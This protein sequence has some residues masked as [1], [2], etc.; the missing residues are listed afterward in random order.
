[1]AIKIKF[2]KIK[3]IKIPPI[4]I[5]PPK[6][7]KIDPNLGRKFTNTMTTVGSTVKPIAN[8]A[9]KTLSKPVNAITSIAKQTITAPLGLLK[10]GTSAISSPIFL[11][12]MLL[13]GGLVL[14]MVIKK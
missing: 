5:P 10:A 14:L 6:P 11:P 13:G 8:D 12:L 4:H 3:P 7:I 1:M 2:P 9:V